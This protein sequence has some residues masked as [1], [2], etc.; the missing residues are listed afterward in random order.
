MNHLVFGMMSSDAPIKVLAV[1]GG[2]AL[3]AMFIGWLA[4]VLAKLS[5]AQKIPP[6]PLRILRVLGGGATGLLVYCFVFGGG[7]GIGGP[8]G[9]FGGGQGGSA[10]K[11]GKSVA[12]SKDGKGDEKS[13]ETKSKEKAEEKRTESQPA[14][15]LRVEVLGNETLMKLARSQTFDTNKRY[16][17]EGSSTLY[18]LEDV[19][20]LILQK[21]KDKPPLRRLV[22]V[23]YRDSPAPDRPQVVELTDWARDLDPERGK[24]GVDL[25]LPDQNAPID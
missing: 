6:W 7:G 8:G 1:V 20:N 19:R 9:W 23:V 5:F 24:V 25:S 11:P 4:Q 17:I 2:A 18:T 10:D 3:G 14:E 22:V 21:R 13:K 16:R 12:S 15:T